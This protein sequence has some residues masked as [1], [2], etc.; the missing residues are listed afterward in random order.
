MAS[1]EPDGNWGSNLTERAAAALNEAIDEENEEEQSVE[2]A[3]QA[4]PLPLSPPGSPRVDMPPTNGCQDADL[5]ELR[6]ILNIQEALPDVEKT[7]WLDSIKS[8]ERNPDTASTSMEATRLTE[9]MRRERV[10]VGWFTNPGYDW[11]FVRKRRELFESIGR[12]SPDDEMSRIFRRAP[13]RFLRILQAVVRELDLAASNAKDESLANM[14]EEVKQ[15]I[16]D[17]IY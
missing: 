2:E 3:A 8:T 5:L 16:K 15:R 10:E 4:A 14:D 1:S 17:N 12:I 13:A 7:F 9:M 6:A 11:Y